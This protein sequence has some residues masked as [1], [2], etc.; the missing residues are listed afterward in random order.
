[1]NTIENKQYVNNKPRRRAKNL[2]RLGVPEQMAWQ[3][4][5]SCM[6]GWAVSCSPILGTTITLDRLKRRGYKSFLYYY[7]EIR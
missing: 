1:M 5:H 7:L 3:W 4:G 6:G 2:I